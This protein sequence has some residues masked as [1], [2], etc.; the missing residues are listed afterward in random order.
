MFSV[1]AFC[2]T[3]SVLFLYCLV[4]CSIV[5]YCFS[6]VI[7]N[8]PVLSMYVISNAIFLDRKCMYVV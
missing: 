2:C 7:G 4:Q 8:V 3:V 5:L 6:I 1:C